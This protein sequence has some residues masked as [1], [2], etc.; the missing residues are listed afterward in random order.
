MAVPMGSGPPPFKIRRYAGF[1]VFQ[2]VYDVEI[3]LN[4][5]PYCNLKTRN[6]E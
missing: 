4:L 1:F 3:M 2:K 6:V 5:Q